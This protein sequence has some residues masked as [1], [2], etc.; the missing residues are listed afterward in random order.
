MLPVSVLNILK[1]QSVGMT[2]E[3]FLEKAKEEKIESPLR[4]LKCLIDQGLARIDHHP[5]P[6]RFK[7]TNRAFNQ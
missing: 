1:Q 2:R 3:H 5:S 4:E 6:T 7:A